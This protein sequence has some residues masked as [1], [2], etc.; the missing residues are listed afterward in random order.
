MNSTYAYLQSHARVS[1]A[2]P[3][4]DSCQVAR[5]IVRGPW[6]FRT[7]NKNHLFNQE[8][9]PLGWPVNLSSKIVTLLMLPAVWKWPCIS[10]GLA[11]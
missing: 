2:Q 9:N 1:V 11:P 3:P 7:S 10:S 4:L 6:I 8:T 5:G